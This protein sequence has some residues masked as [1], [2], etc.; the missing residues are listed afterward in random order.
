MFDQR[1]TADSPPVVLIGKN[2]ADRMFAG[3]SPVGRKLKYAS[4]DAPPLE[5][6]GVV[7]DVKIT[8]VDEAVKPVLYY[9]F[10]QGSS[11]VANLV[12]RTTND[13]TSLANSVRNE[14]RNLEPEAAMLN[15]NTMDG[16]I[17]QTQASFMRRF[18]ALMIGIFAAVALVL[19]SIGIY[20]VVSYSVSQQT[21]YIGIRMALGARPG[22]ILK[23]VMKQGLLIALLGV[24][25]GVVAAFALMRLLSSLLF[26]VTTTDITTFTVVA[27]VLFVVA[28]VACLLPAR[29]ATK[30]DPLVAL[31]Y[32]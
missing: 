25:I 21:H 29:R 13:P 23:M 4:V 2:I 24:G 32:E 31:R 14:V 6:V 11:T 27:G 30:V 10:R 1:D 26:E 18:P 22:D 28:M 8:G 12:V 3:R 17:S 5:I 19:A 15:V 7:G 16:M 9:P 20:G